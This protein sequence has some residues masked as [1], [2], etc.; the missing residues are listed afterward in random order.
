MAPDVFVV[1]GG[2]KGPRG[3][4]LQWVEGGV[5]MDRVFESSRRAT[6]KQEMAASALL[7]RSTASRSNLRL[8]PD[9]TRLR[10][11]QQG[12]VRVGAPA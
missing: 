7:P 4:Y 3:S 10:L 11:L 12:D 2:P 8:R 1:S 9:L 6:P 5:P